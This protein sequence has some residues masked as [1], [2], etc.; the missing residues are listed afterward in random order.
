MRFLFL[1]LASTGNNKQTRSIPNMVWADE[2]R[3][4]SYSNDLTCTRGIL[5]NMSKNQ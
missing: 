4:N 1:A 2:K 5:N 3:A